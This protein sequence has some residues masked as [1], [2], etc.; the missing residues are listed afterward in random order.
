[1]RVTDLYLKTRSKGELQPVDS[2]RCTTLGIDLNLRCSPLRQALLTSL[3]I[4]HQCGLKPSDLR[5]NIVVD[6]AKLY[7]LPSGSILQIGEAVVRVTFH[8]EPC[9]TVLKHVQLRDILHKRGVF[10]QFLN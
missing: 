3:P 4:L 9:R 6:F 10:G 5:E 1:M 8:C 7:D 2:L